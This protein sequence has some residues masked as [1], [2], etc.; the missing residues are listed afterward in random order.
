MLKILNIVIPVLNEEARLEKGVRC[1]VAFLREQKIPHIITLADNGSIDS[2]PEIAKSLSEELSSS[3]EDFCSRVEYLRVAQRGVGLALRTAIAHNA[4]RERPCD[5]IGYM[6]IDLS[7]DLIHL[8]RVYNELCNGAK[9]VVGSRLLKDSE[10]IGRSLRREI[11]SR[12][13]NALLR[14]TLAVK[15][16][17]AMCGFKF[18]QAKTAEH[19]KTLCSEDNGWFYCAQMLVRAQYDGIKITEIPVRWVD[20]PTGSN[21]KVFSLSK[22]YLR[23]IWRLRR[24]LRR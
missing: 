1:A 4:S 10:V 23:E 8:K 19:L 6:D 16:H 7:T 11:L 24:T 2:T 13:L 22:N 17:D 3:G 5:F 14:I 21:V 20:E 18:Y 15:F 9:I 12:G